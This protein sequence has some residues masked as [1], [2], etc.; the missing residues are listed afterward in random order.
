MPEIEKDV[1]FNLIGK[2]LTGHISNSENKLLSDWIDSSEDARI[3]YEDIKLYWANIYFYTGDEA[4]VSQKE[5]RD[6]IWENVFC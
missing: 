4:L 5:L 2:K 1:I 3:C 6:K